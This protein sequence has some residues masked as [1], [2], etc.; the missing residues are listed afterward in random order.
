MTDKIFIQNLEVSCVIGTLLRERKK[1]QK[2]VIDLEFPAPIRKAA[3]R[4]DLLDALNYQKIAEHATEFVA[5]SR[6]YLLET[7]AERLAQAL[8]REF[9]LKSILLHISKPNAIRNA[10][11]VGVKI[12]R[13]LKKKSKR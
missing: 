9:K 6:F 7:L 5:K 10:E 13:T 2:V 12:R 11:S 3:R 8:L 4:D 1:R